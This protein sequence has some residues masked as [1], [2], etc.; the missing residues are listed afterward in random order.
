MDIGH[1]RPSADEVD[2]IVGGRNDLACSSRL[3]VCQSRLLNPL[4]KSRPVVRSFLLRLLRAAL[5]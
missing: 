1:P 5:D 2:H 4:P 3:L